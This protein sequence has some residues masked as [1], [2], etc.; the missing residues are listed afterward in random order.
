[1]IKV[2]ICQEDITI[3][4]AFDLGMC[5]QVDRDMYMC[6][7]MYICVY[8]YQTF[9]DLKAD[10]GNNTMIGDFNILFLIIQTEYQ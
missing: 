9:I 10:I 1:M 6:I 4:Y 5:V 2:T 3:I 7:F 8:L